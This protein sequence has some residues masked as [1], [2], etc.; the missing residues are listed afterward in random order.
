MNRHD[1]MTANSVIVNKGSGVL[2]NSMTE[3]YTYVLTAKHAVLEENVVQKIDGTFINVLGVFKHE[4]DNVDCAILI[5]DYQPDIIQRTYDIEILPDSASLVL[6]GFPMLRREADDK[7]KHQNGVFLEALNNKFI[8]SADGVPG[9]EVILGMSGGGVYYINDDNAYLIGIEYAMDGA[10]EVEFFGRLKCNSLAFFEEI[11]EKNGIAPMVPC[12]LECF[13]RIRDEV[14]NFNVADL[15]NVEKLRKFLVG[16]V[17]KVIKDGLSPYFLMQRYNEKL[18][19][20]SKNINELKDKELWVAYCEFLIICLIID[21][22]EKADQN[23]LNILDKNRRFLYYNSVE[24]WTRKLQEILIYAQSIF[25]DKGTLIITSPQRN[26]A[27]LP[28]SK[29]LEYVIDNISAVPQVGYGHEIDNT[30]ENLYKNLVITHLQAL[31]NHCVL[32]KEYDYKDINSQEMINLF[33]GG[34]HEIIK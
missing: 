15:T 8:L 29:T 32:D 5:V 27:L 26:A 34:Y 28:H 33:R 14:F 2:V 24:N 12:F 6:V 17:D 3:D 9:Q 30:Y 4:A 19:L 11:I 25:K 23:Y 31:H 18:L 7:I 16:I 13:S 1:F 20:S 10:D 22:P 21:G